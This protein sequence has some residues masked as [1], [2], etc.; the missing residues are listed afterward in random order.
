MKVGDLVELSVLAPG[1]YMRVDDVRSLQ[2]YR[3]GEEGRYTFGKDQDYVRSLRVL[4][5]EP[6]DYGL[7][8]MAE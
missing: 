7:K 8:I 6:T 3:S 4:C 1:Q 5:F 2:T